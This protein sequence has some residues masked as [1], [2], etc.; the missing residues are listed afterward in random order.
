MPLSEET[1]VWP[2]SER[3]RVRW[4]KRMAEHGVNE[5]EIL[6][7]VRMAH[8]ESVVMRFIEFMDVGETN[9][10]EMKDVVPMDEILEMI[11][12]EFPLEPLAPQH[13]GEVA[14]RFR[15]PN[16]GGEIGIISSVTQPFCAGCQRL[17]LS[18]DGNLFTCLFSAEGHDVKS[19]LRSEPD[20]DAL[21]RLVSAGDGPRIPR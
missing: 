4:L 8:E 18:A 6:P 16:G 17:R 19:L 2:K 13:P 7:L 1:P 9:G 11:Q 10:W 20:D 3:F 14:K 15:I 5:S 21:R 12:G